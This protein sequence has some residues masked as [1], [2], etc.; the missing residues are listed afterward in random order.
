MIKSRF[1]FTKLKWKN[2]LSYGNYWTELN[3]DQGE[4]VVISG[5]NGMGK[6][7]V[8]DAFYFVLTGKP[9]RSTNI[10]G[11]VNSISNKHCKIE[12]TFTK[13]EDEYIIKRGI[14]PN[15]FQIYKNNELLP[16]DGK[17]ITYYQRKLEEITGLTPNIIKNTLLI[18]SA[19]KS[20][21]N[22][23][24]HEKRSFIDEIFPNL[25]VFVKML[26]LEKSMYDDLSDKHAINKHELDVINKSIQHQKEQVK[27]YEDIVKKIKSQKKNDKKRLEDRL[28]FLA[29]KNILFKENIDSGVVQRN[30]IKTKMKK[31]AIKLNKIVDLNIKRQ[32]AE[33]DFDELT[34]KT[35]EDICDKCGQDLPTSKVKELESERQDDL[36]N[37]KEFFTNT[38]VSDKMKILGCS[39]ED[40]DDKIEGHEIKVDN[41][42]KKITKLDEYILKGEKAIFSNNRRMKELEQELE[43]FNMELPEK[44][45][46][47]IKE[48]LEKAKA[49][50]K[51][52]KGQEHHLLHFK[53]ANKVLLGDELKSYIIA[54]YIPAIN[55]NFNYYLEM[56]NMD[57]KIKFDNDFDWEILS[58]RFKNY[59]YENFSTG[60]RNRLNLA[61]LFTFIQLAKIITFG[62]S[63]LLYNFLGIDEF[64]DNGMDPEG[65]E[66][67]LNLL[68][69]KNKSENITIF[70][71]SHKFD[72][73]NTNFKTI[74][75]I[76]EQGFSQMVFD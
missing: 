35:I 58:R 15:Y 37:L 48:N 29:E 68:N 75:V 9:Y 18:N 76:K 49:M 66:D 70:L 46:I 65:I 69:E 26:K 32:D 38:V 74:D 71:I 24:K 8:M 33:D 19:L 23:S 13:D 7:T 56:F 60:E 73:K 57:V 28:T 72:S 64:L 34:I 1:R 55:E 11:L 3:L 53:E 51:E 4:I 61:L 10:G 5:G 21:F 42:E 31:V 45:I 44:P 6:S 25:S 36:K 27:Q 40:I 47:N 17:R 2:F 41:Y 63:Q 59:Q 52:M 54:N 12:I 14:R 30:E 22:L 39:I 50:K 20:F 67:C 16:E 43:M 62:K